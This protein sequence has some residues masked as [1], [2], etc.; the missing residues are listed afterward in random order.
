MIRLSP[1]IAV[2]SYLI[3]LCG[4]IPL[5][6]WLEPVPRLLL[7]MGMMAGIWQN[8]RG[9]W[10]IRNWMLNAAAIPLFFYYAAQFSRNNAV[11]PMVSLLA[12][13]LTA[14]L[15]GEKSARHYLQIQALS[16]FCLASSSLFDLSPVFLLYLACLLLL[17]ALMLVLL[18]F[19]SDDRNMTLSRLDLRRV[20]AAGLLMPLASIPLLLFLFPVLPRTQFPLWHFLAAP[21]TRTSGFSDRVETGNSSS[22]G[23]SRQT[24]FRVEMPRLPQQQLYWRGTVFNRLEG[25]RW[26]R[27]S[28]V[29][30]ERLAYGPP[31]VSQIIYPEPS[32]VR[33]LPA[34]D[35]AAD[36]RAYRVRRSADGVYELSQV[37]GKRQ[38]Y[39]AESVT[40]GI[41]PV[42][43]SID[44]VFYLRLP[45]GVPGRIRSLAA[46][47]R[48]K[49]ANAAERIELLE[50]YFRS[51]GFRYAM[52]G[53][54]TGEHALEEFLF[55]NR[56]GH[57][58][59]FASAFA[60]LARAAGIP[61]RLVAGYL[62][63]EYN[64][65]GGY[66]LVSE[67]MAH[68]WVEV[69]VA[70]EGW[71]RID[72]SAFAVNAGAIWSGRRQPDF[73]L[74][75][76][77][78]LDSLDHAWNRSVITY[79]LERQLTVAR[80]VGQRLQRIRFDAIS[81]PSRVFMAM[82][83]VIVATAFIARRCRWLASSRER[84]L[85][86]YY[87][88]MARDCGVVARPGQT[89]LFELAEQSG[90]PAA[91]EFAD[92]YGSAVYH[93]RDLTREETKALKRLLRAGFKLP[94]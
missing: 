78:L 1:L 4:V 18:T 11:Q 50:R 15:L 5:F 7:V 68:V 46:D 44:D 94:S 77:M 59:F 24:V 40:N 30:Q 51:G 91:R 73:A 2:L 16:L 57:C 64:Q 31:R 92:I 38:S 20:L 84:L 70:G 45:D 90:S 88:Q 39:A 55:E 47:I 63:G 6:P 71:R 75:L 21:V 23:E 22:V 29:P 67:Q 62:G 52:S 69:F 37:S 28:A 10:P 48:R 72:P 87:R 66:Y 61:A 54:P 33:I 86:R 25:Q 74:R 89:G 56:R 41:L 79:D 32:L 76:R 14:R 34:L 35:A 81:G 42:N 49:G 26:V 80:D 17:A 82:L 83:S 3:V 19:Y 58:E 9:D 36:I 65:L 13:M 93:D 60:V 53:L 85:M 8:W 27:D 12:V 43:G